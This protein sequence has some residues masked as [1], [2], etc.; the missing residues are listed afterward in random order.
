V[1]VNHRYKIIDKNT[2]AGVET[3]DIVTDPMVQSPG[4]FEIGWVGL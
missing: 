2:P 1:V 4:D 3:K